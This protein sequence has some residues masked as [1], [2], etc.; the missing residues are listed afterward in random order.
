MKIKHSKLEE[1]TEEDYTNLI[2]TLDSE[3]KM[4]EDERDKL[5]YHIVDLSEHPARTDLLFYPAPGD[6]DTPEGIVEV[7]KKWRAENGKPGFKPA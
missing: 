3:T 1:Y 4:P 6:S 2:R 5:I 7:I